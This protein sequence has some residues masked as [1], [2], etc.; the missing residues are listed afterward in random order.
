M[1]PTTSKTTGS[2]PK[3]YLLE[4]HNR[5][6]ELQE[7][8]SLRAT[9]ILTLSNQHSAHID[10]DA[11][12]ESSLANAAAYLQIKSRFYNL[13]IVGT[14]TNHAITSLG[15]GIHIKIINLDTTHA[16]SFQTNAL[17]DRAFSTALIKQDDEPSS[18]PGFS[19]WTS[20]ESSQHGDHLDKDTLPNLQ[21]EYGTRLQIDLPEKSVLDTRVKS[22]SISKVSV[23][24]GLRTK[25]ITNVQGV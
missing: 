6:L 18:E 11:E 24:L 8:G 21:L 20:P 3:S 13:H 4:T 23:S 14:T 9:P 1:D 16:S 2:K 25:P 15:E 22:S 10:H 19:R 12:Q 5:I 7:I 17:L